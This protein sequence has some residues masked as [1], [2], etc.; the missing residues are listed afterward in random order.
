MHLVGVSMK[1]RVGGGGYG[2]VGEADEREPL[3]GD[4]GREGWVRARV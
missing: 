4:C 2:V 1:A 3:A